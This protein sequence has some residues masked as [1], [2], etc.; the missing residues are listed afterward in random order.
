MEGKAPGGGA[1]ASAS[2]ST[3]SPSP[4][5]AAAGGGWRDGQAS[6]DAAAG[7]IVSKRYSLL[8]VDLRSQTALL[9]AIQRAGLVADAPTYILSECV[10]VYMEPQ[11]S[12]SVVSW[13][14]GHFRESAA[15]VV[16][17][18]IKP[19]D[20]FGRQMCS[21]LE[22]RGCPLKGVTSTPTKA[23]H[24]K[25]MTDGGW[26]SADCR[27]MDELYK[28][29]WLDVKDK[30]RAESLEMFDEFEEWHMIQEH[31]CITIGLNAKLG[32]NA[33]SVWSGFGALTLPA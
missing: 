8:P 9:A 21:N 17:E 11:E 19:Y 26:S 29:G 22:S 31:Y 32:G 20:A 14:A 4:A 18:Q 1:S 16:Y 30:A 13:L 10:L 33:T 25:R 3:P 27:D 5:A 6:F 24:M 23:A 15:L 12:A 7:E 28:G 2:A